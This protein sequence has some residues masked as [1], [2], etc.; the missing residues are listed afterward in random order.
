M[1]PH[2]R[3]GKAG[4]SHLESKLAEVPAKMQPLARCPG[5]KSKHCSNPKFPLFTNAFYANNQRYFR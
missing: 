5:V 1:T 2:D 4:I 3:T